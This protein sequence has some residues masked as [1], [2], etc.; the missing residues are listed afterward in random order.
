MALTDLN[1][2]EARNQLTKGDISAVDLTEDSGSTI[3]T[4][5]GFPPVDEAYLG[6]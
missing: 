2:A 6:E 3:D 1:I 5:L 4:V